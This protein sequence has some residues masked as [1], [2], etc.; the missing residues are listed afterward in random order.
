[1]L[2]QI[3]DDGVFFLLKVGSAAKPVDVSRRIL[4][5]VFEP[6]MI[7]LQLRKLAPRASLQP[8]PIGRRAPKTSATVR[9][10]EIVSAATEIEGV[11]MDVVDAED[12]RVVIMD[13]EVEDKVEG[14]EGDEEEEEE[15]EEEEREGEAG[16][17]AAF[18]AKV[19]EHDSSNT[20]GR[21]LCIHDGAEDQIVVAVEQAPITTSDRLKTSPNCSMFQSPLD[22]KRLWASVHAFFEGREFKRILVLADSEMRT[23]RMSVCVG[24]LLPEVS[25]ASRRVVIR[26]HYCLKQQI[27]RIFT[28]NAI[29]GSF[30]A[31]GVWPFNQQTMLDHCPAYRDPNLF[32]EMRKLKWRG[33]FLR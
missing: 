7:Q 13:T 33:G 11:E 3:D 5:D 8:L 10:M 16:T 23:N 28:E 22:I 6:V 25:L 2:L 26:F 19:P 24:E 12:T 15:E 4:M 27:L 9:P 14:E 18:E 31:A 20:R 30:I 32:D 1:M 21:A 29:S 17:G